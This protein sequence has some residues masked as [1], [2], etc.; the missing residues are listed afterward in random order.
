MNSPL[1]TSSLT[2]SALTPSLSATNCISSV[3]MPFRA[4]CIWVYRSCFPSRAS[5]HSFLT[6]G[7]PSW[8]F[9][10]R[11]PDV[12]YKSIDGMSGSSRWTLRKGTRSSCP[13]ASCVATLYS[14]VE[15]GNASLYGTDWMRE[16][17][18]LKGSTV[19]LVRR[20]D[21]TFASLVTRSSVLM[22][23]ATRS[24]DVDLAANPGAKASAD[25]A[26]TAAATAM[27]RKSMVW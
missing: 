16:N 20:V 22:G 23:V 24:A 2:N 21:L 10:S 12:S 14:F 8:G 26:Q 19:G 4:K 6:F 11:G 18:G 27:D 9:T 5:T 1:A 15:L 13:V 25:G 17:S 3:I 7:S